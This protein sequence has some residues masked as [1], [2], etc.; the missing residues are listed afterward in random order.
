VGDGSASPMPPGVP[1][2][3]A[4]PLQPVITPP[5]TFRD[6]EPPRSH[7]NPYAAGGNADS[8][9]NPNASASVGPPPGNPAGPTTMTPYTWAVAFLQG[10]GMPTTG[11]NI[12]FVMS[13]EAAEG[14]HWSDAA[15]YN[16]LNTTQPGFGGVGI[17]S[18]GVKAYPSW[19]AGLQAN[20]Q[21]IKNGYY[22]S[23]LN[24][25]R[26]GNANPQDL[27]NA[28]ANSPWG[29]QHF[30]GAMV[31]PQASYSG[32]AIDA[33]TAGGS[34]PGLPPDPYQDIAAPQLSLDALRSQYPLVAAVVSAVPELQAIF[35][36]AVA[37]NWS[38]DRFI[39][40]VQNSNWWAT[41]S[42][43]ARQM[44]ALML[45]D[46]ATYQRQID[47]LQATLTNFAAQLGARPN[48]Q[49]I[50]SL[51]IDALTNGY[52]QNQAMLREKFAQYVT[53][54]SGLHFGG[55]AGSDE[56]QLRQAM[57]D[58][59]VFLPEK[60]LDQNIQSIV[61]GTSDVN[62]VTSQL[63][64]QAESTYPAY[65]NE[66]KNGMNVSTIAE[67]FM[68][69]AMQLLEK[70]P[71]EINILNPMIKSALQNTVGGKPT[72]LSLTDFE[73]MVRE[74]PEWLQTDNARDALMQTAHQ[75]LTNF[76]FTY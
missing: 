62:A 7:Y 14:G 55:E 46:P 26:Q 39:S 31:G 3:L 38:T 2:P 73:N 27:A 25:L 1:N 18:V 37:G 28:V 49:Q 29:T 6:T 35:N 5:H 10:L 43:T 61:G 41:H 67:P 24:L 33:A 70:G 65:A 52:D 48:H 53:P 20:I 51:A 4:N 40:A 60:T 72:P 50:L 9:F 15:R 8:V 47:N 42:D 32:P 36:Q 12:E 57:M 44:F 58:L 59:G 17:N 16:P 23:I 22:T 13:W 68:Q 66:I 21:V 11:S 19:Q 63:R 74:R 75:V 45:S 71:G 30:S 56:S 69:Q 54:V 64:T 76:G 34:A